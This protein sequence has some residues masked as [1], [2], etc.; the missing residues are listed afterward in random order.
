MVRTI[1]ELIP[2]RF[3]PTALLAAFPPTENSKFLTGIFS[4]YAKAIRHC[5]VSM[6]QRVSLSRGVIKVSIEASP[7]ESKSVGFIKVLPSLL[8]KLFLTFPRKRPELFLH[9]HPYR[10]ILSLALL[11]KPLRMKMK[12]P[13][14]PHPLILQFHLG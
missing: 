3:A 5:F 2:K 10:S 8:L 1:A 14:V 13:T 11:A 9:F 12:V 4:P 7:I 6:V